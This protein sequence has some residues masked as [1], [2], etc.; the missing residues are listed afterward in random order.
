MN[1]SIHRGGRRQKG[2][3]LVEIAV[4][5]VI[6]GLLLGGVLKG[7][8]LIANARARSLISDMQGIQT[9]YY[10]FQDRY[11]HIPGDWGAAGTAIPGAVSCAGA[12]CGNGL[13]DNAAESLVAFNQ[14][15]AAG[16]IGGSYNATG[17]ASALNSPTNKWGGV[18]QIITDDNY[19][20]APEGT[21]ARVT[22]IKTGGQIPVAVVREV[23]VKLDNED[24]SGGA[25]RLS[26]W[27]NGDAACATA[28][29]PGNWDAGN[30]AHASCGGALLLN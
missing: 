28:G 7:Q 8:E 24:P 5:L 18:M 20:V 22:N 14:L 29:A 17:P 19:Q 11:R 1:R 15:Q 23:D 13:I 30:S 16:F 27:N 12:V 3:T 21:A 9:A 25:F 26:T 4:V 6:V 10:G 2:F